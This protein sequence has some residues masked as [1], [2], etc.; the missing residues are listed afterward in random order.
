MN[1]VAWG[2]IPELEDIV[3]GCSDVFDARVVRWVA[4]C[5]FDPMIF[6]WQKI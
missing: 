4:I 2:D 1:A 5:G 3:V 6:S